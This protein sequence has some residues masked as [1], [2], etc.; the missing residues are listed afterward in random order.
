MKH[1]KSLFS[2]VLCFALFSQAAFGGKTSKNNA[3]SPST[4]PL[5]DHISS[6]ESLSADEILTELRTREKL[7]FHRAIRDDSANLDVRTSLRRSLKDPQEEVLSIDLYKALIAKQKAIYGVDN[8]IDVHKMDSQPGA[9]KILKNADGTVALVEAGDLRKSGNKF[10]LKTSSFK[11]SYNLC[12]DEP[13]VDQ[14]LG[15][16]CTGF[17]VAPDIVVTAGHCI[18]SADVNNVK[19]VFDYALN[20]SGQLRKE[21]EASEVYSAK[22]IIARKKRSPGPDYSIVRLDRSVSNHS[23][24]KLRGSGSLKV[25][26]GVYVI[27]HPC[28]LPLKY[29]GGA[30]VRA[31][32]DKT[33]FVAN[34]DTYGGNSGSPVFNSAS[35]EVEGILVSGEND[36]VTVNGSC[37][38]SLVCPQNGCSGENITPVAQF[39]DKLSSH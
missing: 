13:F 39:I 23:P 28:G 5:A 29:A 1:A 11:S 27:G 7:N 21:F 19:F 26:D 18:T 30:K 20:N 8:R 25:D 16:F 15:P 10:K 32:P 36:F 24:L 9:T 31:Y 4:T 12:D 34:L 3:N 17:L 33:N 22:E 14:Q 37:N 35:H 38:N 6:A 2:A